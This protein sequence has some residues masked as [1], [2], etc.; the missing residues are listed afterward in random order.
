MKK[1]NRIYVIVGAVLFFAAAFGFGFL[2]SHLMN[3]SSGKAVST[4]KVSSS[5]KITSSGDNERPDFYYTLNMDQ[6]IEYKSHGSSLIYVGNESDYRKEHF[7]SSEFI[8]WD[9]IA[10]KDTDHISSDLGRFLFVISDTRESS[11]K[12]CKKLLEMGFWNVFDCGGMD[13]AFDCALSTSGDEE[14]RFPA[15]YPTTAYWGP[16]D[17]SGFDVEEPSEG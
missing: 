4:E 15:G 7:V 8:S 14:G 3:T 11:Q 12:A 1:N 13:Q 2:T 16:E 6:L 5:E 17:Y 10:A 9:V